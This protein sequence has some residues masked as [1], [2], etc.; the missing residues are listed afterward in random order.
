MHFTTP[1]SKTSSNTDTTT[2]DSK[3]KTKVSSKVCDLNNSTLSDAL[4]Q[5]QGELNDTILSEDEVDG[6]PVE[7]D[8]S[9]PDSAVRNGQQNKKRSA[10]DEDRL[11]N[12]VDDFFDSLPDLGEL[13]FVLERNG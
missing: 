7:A 4:S 5:S 6:T 11:D 13:G 1:K 2:S 10:R 3:K 8:Q 9:V 12:E